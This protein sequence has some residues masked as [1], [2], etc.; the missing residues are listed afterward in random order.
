MFSKQL[1]VLVGGKGTRL[2]ALTQNTPKP[3]MPIS[4]DRVFLDYFLEAATRQGFSDILFLAGHYGEQVAQRYDG[5]TLNGARLRVMI[6]PEPKGTGGAFKYFY[7]QL[8][9]TFVAANGDTLFDINMRA[10]DARLQASPDLSGVLALRLVDD[11]ARYGSV[12]Q[13]NRGLITGFTEKQKSGVAIAGNINGGIYALRRE[14]IARLPDGPSSIETDLFPDLA[15]DQR[16]AG[17]ES[18]GY[19]LDIGLPETLNIARSELPIR[20]RSVLFLD[21]DGVLNIEKNYLYRPEDFEWVEG[22]VDVIRRRNDRGDAVVVVTNQAGVARGMY[23][24]DDVR[25]L[26]SYIQEDLYARGAFVDAFYYCPYHEAATVDQYRVKNH[27]NR[28]PNPG[29]LLTAA[30]DLN[31]D[32]SRAIMIGDMETD[33]AAAEAASIKGYLFKGGDLSAFEQTITAPST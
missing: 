1:V 6:E 29:M 26:H 21:R 33:V 14:A 23:G 32:M 31:L 2:G 24:E 4:N 10:L 9:P 19:F 13:N 30:R 18:S 22:A 28:K 27:P 12:T 8:A 20:R 16:L 7:D 5:R 17:I 25:D 3:L 11:V 15:A